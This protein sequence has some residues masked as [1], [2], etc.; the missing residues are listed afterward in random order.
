MALGDIVDHFLDEHR[1]A[2]ARAAEQADLAALCIRRDQVDH[3]DA[4]DQN[5]AFGRLV[6]E[7]GGLGVDRRAADGV[8]RRSDEHT[9]ELQSLMRISYAVFCL[10]KNKITH[11]HQYNT[12]T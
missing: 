10:N 1:L 7:F 3:L 4:G 8:H 6:D 2:D 5:A 11:L 12:T 9:S